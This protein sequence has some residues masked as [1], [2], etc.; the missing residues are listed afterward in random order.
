[1][2]VLSL[3]WRG[4]RRQALRTLRKGL[5]MLRRR[6][7]GTT[8]R[9]ALPHQRRRYGEIAETVRS[10]PGRDPR[11]ARFIRILRALAR[12]SDGLRDT[13]LGDGNWRRL[14]TGACCGVFR[15]DLKAGT[16]RAVSGFA[17]DRA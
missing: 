9:L 10:A 3:C 1:M 7:H 2:G 14:D 11:M 12:V 8:G 15:P 5:D 16:A 13:G 6:K 4:A 17:S